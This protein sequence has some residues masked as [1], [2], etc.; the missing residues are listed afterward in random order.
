MVTGPT[1]SAGPAPADHN[2]ASSSRD[3]ASSWRTLDHL[4]AR[5]YDQGGEPPPLARQRLRTWTTSTR[6]N[7]T[8]H[9]AQVVRRSL[10]FTLP[11]PTCH[12]SRSDRGR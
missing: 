2:R 11:N 12:L 10:G 7:H 9:L 3:T 6:H 1:R 8:P 5:S 4:W